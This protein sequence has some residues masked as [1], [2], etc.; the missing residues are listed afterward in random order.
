MFLLESCFMYFF[1]LC[2]ILQCET[3]V[4]ELLVK[5]R[6]VLAYPMQGGWFCL[7]PLLRFSIGGLL[8]VMFLA[9]SRALLYAS[10][11]Y[12]TVMIPDVACLVAESDSGR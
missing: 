2:T 8:C 7:S 5:S 9:H 1:Q 6:T 10:A 11:V 3:S 12:S 4:Q